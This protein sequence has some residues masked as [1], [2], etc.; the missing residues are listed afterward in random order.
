MDSNNHNW[1]DYEDVSQQS[2][3]MGPIKKVCKGDE[4]VEMWKVTLYVK[5]LRQQPLDI[6]TINEKESVND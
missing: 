3:Y 5:I 1:H 6:A 4:D 2:K